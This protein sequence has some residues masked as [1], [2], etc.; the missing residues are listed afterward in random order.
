MKLDKKEYILR[1]MTFDCGVWTN[2]KTDVI[3]II[4]VSDYTLVF[5]DRKQ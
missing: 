1:I 4:L 3:Y 5:L 2:L